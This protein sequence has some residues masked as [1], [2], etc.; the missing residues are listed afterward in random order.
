MLET[1]TD[2]YRR[3]NAASPRLD[4]VRV[5][6]DI[7]TFERDGVVSVTAHSGGVSTFARPGEDQVD[8]VSAVL[9]TVLAG[10]RYLFRRNISD[11]TAF[12]SGRSLHS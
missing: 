10:R 11:A 4:H 5:G 6:K 1:T 2:L 7:L 12:S 9:R 3:G 8:G